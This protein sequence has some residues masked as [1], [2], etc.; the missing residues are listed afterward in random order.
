ML[1]GN[2]DLNNA[3][4]RGFLKEGAYHADTVTRAAFSGIYRDFGF[5]EAVSRDEETLSYFAAPSENLRIL[6][7]D[8]TK[9]A[10]NG[11]TLAGGGVSPATQA[12]ITEC[13][14]N[15]RAGKIRIV[16]AMHHS[17]LDHSTMITNNYTMD[18]G[19]ELAAF[20]AKLGMDFAL[21]GHIH[22]QDISAL[23][24]PGGT[25]YD[26]ATN[27]FSV[28]PH[29]YGTL[30][31]GEDGTRVDYRTTP[32]DVESWAAAADSDDS[33]LINF[34]EFSEGVFRDR[35]AAMIRDNAARLG[36]VDPLQID[37]MAA[38][39]ETLNVRFFSGREALNSDGIL[40]SEGYG[41]L[42][43]LR[44]GFLSEYAQSIATDPTPDDN[45]LRLGP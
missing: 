26:I 17:L 20:F 39:M 19:R 33:R 5:G 36:H 3:R 4:A 31:I 1:P 29:N 16:P 9:Q 10:D 41:L 28:Y 24:T 45:E 6:M 27:A 18:G 14:K 34:T 11:S 37:A 42:K 23:D 38:A 43:G 44:S 8:T 32:L 35:A 25:V 13:T 40:E 21:S 12:W 2:H 15:A 30:R 7:L 22:I